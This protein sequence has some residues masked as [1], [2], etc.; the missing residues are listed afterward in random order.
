MFK[1]LSCRFFIL[2]K[3]FVVSLAFPLAAMEDNHRLVE[4]RL[5]SI[6]KIKPKISI[7]VDDLGDNSIIARQLAN[8]PVPLTMAILPKTPHAKKIA[9]LANAKGHEVIMHLPM[10]AFS[11]PDLLGPGAIYAD[12]AE[13]EI[14]DTILENARSI[15]YLVGFNNHMGS[16]LT[17]DE[18][19]M[20]WVMGL[21]STQSWYFLDSK[22]SEDS[23]AESAAKKQGLPA[24]GRDIF[25]DHHNPQ[26]KA[27]LERILSEQLNKAKKI[28]L[29]TGTAVVICHPYPET[30]AFLATEIPKHQQAFEFVKLSQLISNKNIEFKNTSSLNVKSVNIAPLK[31][32]N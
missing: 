12:M 26:S 13:S 29:R 30:F 21:A 22:T 9:N 25:L 10:E 27:D 32:A 20:G 3:V 1:H 11:R 4:K 17:E 15:P 24:I 5:A 14:T 16:L 7:V 23:I 19:K 28:A 18:E 31:T 6:G 8:L 2:F